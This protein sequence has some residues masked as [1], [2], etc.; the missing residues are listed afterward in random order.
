[1]AR[2]TCVFYWD[3]HIWLM[4]QLNRSLL[5]RL[6]FVCLRGSP[7]PVVAARLAV[8]QELYHPARQQGTSCAG[9]AFPLHPGNITPVTELRCKGCLQ[10]VL[11][12][13]KE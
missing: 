13:W 8:G 12:R 2:K 3:Q 4:Q 9:L 10:L 1:M 11:P 6:E 7:L 5:P